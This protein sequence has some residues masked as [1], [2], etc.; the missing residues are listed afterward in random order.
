MN[1]TYRLTI[2]HVSSTQGSSLT[3]SHK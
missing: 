2:S 3:P 1:N